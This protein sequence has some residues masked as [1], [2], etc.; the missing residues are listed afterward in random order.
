MDTYLFRMAPRILS[1]FD[2]KHPMRFDSQ[3]G[4]RWGGVFS[5]FNYF[6]ADSV[7]GRRKSRAIACVTACFRI[8]L[9]ITC[10]LVTSERPFTRAINALAWCTLLRYSGKTPVTKTYVYETDTKARTIEVLESAR[11]RAQREMIAV[12]CLSA[13]FVYCIRF[14]RRK[15]YK[16]ITLA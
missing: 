10:T 2:V 1:I 11:M 15:R 8:K 5:C 7:R 12:V 16:I 3:R 9:A 13:N 14:G 6:R 4:G